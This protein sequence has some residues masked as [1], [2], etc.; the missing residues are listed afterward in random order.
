MKRTLRKTLALALALAL[1][2]S[3]GAAA[4]PDVPALSVVLDGQPMSFADAQPVLKDG[5]V[6][7]PYRAVFEALGAEVSYDASAKTVS[8]K[9]DDVSVSFAIGANQVTVTENGKTETVQVD[10]A[11][12]I[13]EASGRTMAPVR[14][15]AQALGAGVGWDSKTKTV[16]IVDP[17]QL[18]KTYGKKFSLM[19]RYIKEASDLQGAA[20][21]FSGKLNLNLS[22]SQNGQLIPIGL[23]GAVSGGS[24]Q[25]LAN[26]KA[27]FSLELDKL[28]KELGAQISAEDQ[29]QLD[30]L[31]NMEMNYIVNLNTGMI[32]LNAPV[33]AELGAAPKADTWYSASINEF[34]QDAL[35]L[36]IDFASLMKDQQSLSTFQAL[37]RGL[38]AG[39]NL[40]DSD[41]Y[42]QIVEALDVCEDLLGDKAFVKNGDTYT[43]KT[44]LSQ[45]G[46]QAAIQIDLKEIQGKLSGLSMNL[47]LSEGENQMTMQLSQDAKQVSMTFKL[48][49][50]AGAGASVSMDFDY[51]VEYSPLKDKLQQEPPAGADIRNLNELIKAPQVT[52][53]NT[54]VSE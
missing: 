17:R 43:S 37:M 2:L 39:V 52:Q 1:A 3:L 11:P 51:S 16:Q 5:R 15:A 12:Y 48:Q 54:K 6:Y 29:A 41:A 21:S 8:A 22:V 7:M 26:M 18:E 25:Q 36:D 33:L 10:A 47:T 31:K 38:T 46:A 53:T 28:L 42:N 44:S 4:A 27:S 13:D 9:R 35:G 23:S 34:Y 45:N 30:Q 19:D 14:F 49:A 32:Y 20:L 40:N 50:D 24:D